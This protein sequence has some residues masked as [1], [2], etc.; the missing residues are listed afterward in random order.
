VADTPVAPAPATRRGAEADVYHGVTVPDPY[1]WLEDG[2]SSEVAEWVALHNTR[3]REA[4][5]ARPSRG[6]WHERLS[7]LAALPTTLSVAV[8]GEYLFVVERP[9]GADQYL[10]TVRSAIDPAVPGRVLLDPAAMAHDGAVAIDW[11]HPSHDGSLIAYGLSEG[12]T[13]NSLLHVMEVATGRVLAD[14]IP[15]CQ[16]GRASCRE[17]VS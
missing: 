13:E 8:A 2:E 7:A 14:R 16:I 9:S 6:R 3:T 17:R 10:L 1:R 15:N 12:G 5:A 11:L 4:L